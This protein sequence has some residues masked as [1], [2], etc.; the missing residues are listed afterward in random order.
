MSSA[1]LRMAAISAA[2]ES[3]EQR[4]TRGGGFFEKNWSFIFNESCAS[5]SAPSAPPRRATL[6]NGRKEGMRAA[7]H[8][9]RGV[10]AEEAR[11]EGVQR[12]GAE[13][14]HP[15]VVVLRAEEEDFL[16]G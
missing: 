6:V 1:R 14:A 9:L 16:C 3:F 10:G 11:L 13:E 8:D 4:G 2:G 5:F 7:P 12:Q 15:L